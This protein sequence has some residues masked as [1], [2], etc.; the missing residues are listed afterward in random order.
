[1][2]GG[3]WSSAGHGRHQER[4]LRLP[5]RANQG[6]TAGGEAANNAPISDSANH[7]PTSDLFI[8][9]SCNYFEMCNVIKHTLKQ[10]IIKTFLI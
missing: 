8:P 3:A 9:F 1:M 5:W 6:D 10:Y 2:Q 4:F 7:A